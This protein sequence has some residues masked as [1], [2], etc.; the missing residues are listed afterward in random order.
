VF[1]PITRRASEIV[2]EV[3]VFVFRDRY[4]AP[5]VLN[6]L[7]RRDGLWSQDL[8]QAVA[9]TLDEESRATVQMSVDLSKREAVGW[10]KLWGS[11]LNSA[12]FVP[13]VTGMVEAADEVS[14]RSRVSKTVSPINEIESPELEWWRESLKDAENFKRD[15]SASIIANSSAIFMMLRTVNASSALEQLRDYGSTIVHATVTKEQDDRLRLML[16]MTA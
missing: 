15:V 9:V 8:E 10:A 3:V 16:K 11:L 2:S 6:E 13:L 1:Q 14:I 12:L 5:E 7:R 4:R